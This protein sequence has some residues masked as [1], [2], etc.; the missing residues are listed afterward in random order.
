MDLGSWVGFLLVLSCAVLALV[1]G[2]GS[3]IV[4]E[5]RAFRAADIR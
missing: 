1:A 3:T 2:I 4:A 5:A